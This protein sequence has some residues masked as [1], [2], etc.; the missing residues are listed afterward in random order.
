MDRSGN[1]YVLYAQ[2]S[3]VNKW[4]P[5]AKNGI[6][7]AGG[8][9]IG[10]AAYQLNSPDGMFVESNTSFIWIADT[11]N[12]RIVRWESQ[13]TSIIVCGS[14]GSAAD[15]FIYPHG[16]FVDITT[17]KTFYVADTGNHRI[18]MWRI[19]NTS[20]I[21]IAGETGVSSSSLSQLSSPVGII[22]DENKN[23]YIVDKGNNRI[24]RW[25]IGSSEGTIIAGSSSYGLLPYQLN[26]PNN[27]RF[28]RNGSLLVVDTGN[29]RIQKFPISCG[30]LI[31]HIKTTI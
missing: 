8:N 14:Y 9:G 13:F 7:V 21:T 27:I 22:V 5:G 23:M 26:M 30:N 2:E 1:I 31:D 25:L 11:Y 20:G 16:L 17:P 24:V 4:I 3:K 10:N 15:Q 18:Q 12:N 6:L 28:D 29:N 19:G